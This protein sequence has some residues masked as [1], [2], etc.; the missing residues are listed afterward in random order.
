MRTIQRK[1][2]PWNDPGKSILE[3]SFAIILNIE[4]VITRKDVLVY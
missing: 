1:S 4:L 2:V 3:A